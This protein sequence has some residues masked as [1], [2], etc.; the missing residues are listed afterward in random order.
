MSLN[1]HLPDGAIYLTLDLL[2]RATTESLKLPQASARL[3]QDVYVKI[4]AIRHAEYLAM[5]P[6]SPPGSES[7]P[8]DESLDA[9]A[10]RWQAWLD[11]LPEE[12]R[13]HRAQQAAEVT[14]RV[15]AAGLTEP[16]MT[17]EQAR[18]LAA[19]ADIVA[20]AVLRLSGLIKETVTASTPADVAEE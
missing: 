12:E 14:Y 9:R 6:P 11:A 8:H 7:W 10:A 15:V 13:Q 20:A 2:E 17:I 19:D 16:R 3:G 1:G 18:G 5:L 4:R